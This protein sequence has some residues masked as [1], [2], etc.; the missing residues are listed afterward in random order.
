[1][2][3]LCDLCPICNILHCLLPPRN[4]MSNPCI[5]STILLA[6]GKGMNRLRQDKQERLSNE[7]NNVISVHSE[8]MP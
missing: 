1:M 4:R 5:S 2:N 8:E 7:I 3:L 6:A